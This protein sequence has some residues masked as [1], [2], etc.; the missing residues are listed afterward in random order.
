MKHGMAMANVADTYAAK[1]RFCHAWLKSAT[2][3]E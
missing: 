1:L 3:Y 2:Q